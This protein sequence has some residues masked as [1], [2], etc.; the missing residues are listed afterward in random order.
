M[1]LHFRKRSLAECKWEYA[2]E[3]GLTVRQFNGIAAEVP[4]KIEAVKATWRRGSRFPIASSGRISINPAVTT[5]IGKVKFMARYGLSPR[6]AAAVAIARRGLKFGER[7]R[8][9][10]ARQLPARNRRRHVWSDWR[11]VLPSVKGR[12][13]TH[14]LFRCPSEGTPGRGSPLSASARSP[15]PERDGFAWGPGCDP[16]AQMVGLTVRPASEQIC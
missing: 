1:D 6:A 3:Y 10:N 15:R 8:S 11:R 7:L 14:A 4:G 16:P 5:V 13:A 12:K 2:R 9:G